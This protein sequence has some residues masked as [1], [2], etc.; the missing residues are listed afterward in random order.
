MR[1]ISENATR[2]RARELRIDCGGQIDV[3]MRP[4]QRRILT[5]AFF[6]LLSFPMADKRSEDS[7]HVELIFGTTEVCK[8]SRL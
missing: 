3:E 6:L 8:G 5:I 7:E 2:A 4:M 1:R